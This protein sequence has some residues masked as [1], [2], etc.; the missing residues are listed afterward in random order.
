MWGSTAMSRTILLRSFWPAEQH[1]ATV[2]LMVG[3]RLLGISL[4]CT[5]D[6]VQG[7]AHFDRA[8]ALYDLAAHRPLVIR[9][10]I[11]TGVSVL[12]YR[13]MALWLL[14]YPETALHETV[15]ALKDA[16]EVSHATTLMYALTMT[17]LTHI[18]RGDYAAAIAQPDEVMSLADEK[19]AGFWKAYGMLV[20]GWLFGLTESDAI[21]MI[22]AGIAAWRST[23]AK[24]WM[25]W[26]PSYLE[27]AHAELGF[28]NAWRCISEA[29]TAMDITTKERWCEAE[30]YRVAGEIALMSPDFNEVKAEANFEHASPRSAGSKPNPGNSAPP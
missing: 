28:D 11:D 2:P 26:Y 14:G 22:N 27:M 9:F 24:L 19:G 1:N 17:S 3:H 8:F 12:S 6:I 16:H 21:G 10:G 30:V 15:R 29:M 5:G 4:L 18:C 23:G 25:P 13:P 7:R 20:R